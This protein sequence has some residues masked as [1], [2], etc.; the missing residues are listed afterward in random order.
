MRLLLSEVGEVGC[1][2]I[3]F[4]LPENNANFLIGYSRLP[5][6]STMF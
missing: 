3:A 5:V 6:G 4:L 2:R 1:R